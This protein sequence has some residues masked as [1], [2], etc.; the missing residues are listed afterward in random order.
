MQLALLAHRFRAVSYKKQF[1]EYTATL[2]FI[3]NRVQYSCRLYQ[4]LIL[5]LIPNDLNTNRCA[6]VLFRAGI[7]GSICKLESLEFGMKVVPTKTVELL[8]IRTE[9]G[10]A[11]IVSGVYVSHLVHGNHN[12]R[13]IEIVPQA[14]ICPFR[15]AIQRKCRMRCWRH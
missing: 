11:R 8:V 5:V 13:I 10:V 6:L 2:D 4:G 3:Y 1:W 15:P 9:F 12:S 14:T 7:Y